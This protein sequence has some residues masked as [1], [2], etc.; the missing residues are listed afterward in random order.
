LREKGRPRSTGSTKCRFRS[1]HRRERIL[2]GG[3][4]GG[5]GG[6]SAGHGGGG[7]GGGGLH[8]FRNRER[9]SQRREKGKR[10]FLIHSILSVPGGKK[11]ETRILQGEE[12]R[13]EEIDLLVEPKREMLPINPTRKGEALPANRKKRGKE[14][15]AFSGKT[16]N[17]PHGV[18]L[19]ENESFFLNDRGTKE[20]LAS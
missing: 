19:K 2:L 6:I 4:E 8:I 16:R 15:P 7:K 10:G 5:E 12:K 20:G 11:K 14:K 3:G 13:G 9:G 17:F 1:G 18:V